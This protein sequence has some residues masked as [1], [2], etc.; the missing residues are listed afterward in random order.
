MCCYYYCNNGIKGGGGK[1]FSKKKK[2]DFHFQ[3]VFIDFRRI[4]LQRVANFFSFFFGQKPRLYTST[5]TYVISIYVSIFGK[6]LVKRVFFEYFPNKAYYFC[7]PF[8][9]ADYLAF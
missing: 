3:T 9:R 4:Q 5:T 8:S 7:F 1:K 2:K 6:S